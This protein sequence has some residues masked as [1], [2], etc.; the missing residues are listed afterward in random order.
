[1]LTA[2]ARSPQRRGHRES[3]VPA[4]AMSDVAAMDIAQIYKAHRGD[5]FLD[6]AGE[7]HP[8]PGALQLVFCDLSTPSQQ[9]NA[10]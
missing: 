6:D 2:T 7:A 1:M 3:G 5:Q 9:W 8:R 4:T 10:Y